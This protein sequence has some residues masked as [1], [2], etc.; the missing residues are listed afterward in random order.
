MNIQTV[1]FNRM[2]W[3]A[4]AVA[5]LVSG[6]G[7]V[8]KPAEPDGSSRVA[9]NSPARLAQLQDR[10]YADRAILT[11]NNQLKAQ[12][13]EL[14]AQLSEMRDIVRSALA[15]PPVPVH[16][17]PPAPQP[18]AAQPTP[19][20]PT[21][22]VGATSA[23]PAKALEVT[24]SGAVVRVFH[25]FAK[26]EFLPTQQTAKVLRAAAPS[27]D[28]IVV[29]GH[30]DSATPNPVDRLI[31][32]ERA[33]KARSWLL[34]NGVQPGTVRLQFRSAGGFISENETAQGRALNRRVDVQLQGSRVGAAVSKS[35]Q[36]GRA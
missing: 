27:A 3:A 8:P 26:T 13:G 36:D 32:I 14:R 20:A 5:A 31:A 9:A 1:R 33:V 19:D 29:R 16:V 4:L 10:V 24:A 34:A 28:S 12:L 21:S 11:E 7:S 18:Q 25:D 6:C 22:N 15:L 2:T 17:V 30:T 23:L 35:L